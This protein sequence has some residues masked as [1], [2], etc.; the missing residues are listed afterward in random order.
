MRILLV[1][2]NYLPEVTGIGPFN[3]GLAEY[4]AAEGHDVTVLTAFPWYPQW[5]IDPAYRR[6]R[7]FMVERIGGVRIIRSPI[8]LPAARQTTFRRVVF[9]SSFALTALPASAGIGGLDAVICVSPPLQL[10]ITA[11]MI[12]RTRRAKLILHV[13][14]IVPDAALSS[15]MMHAGRAVAMS[16]GLEGWVYRR[17]DRITVISEGFRENLLAKRVPVDKL[18]VLPNWVETGLFKSKADPGVRSALG[19]PN[20]ET[21]VLHTGN[22]GAKQGLETVVDA[23]AQLKSEDIAITLIGDGQARA[24]LESR[25]AELGV[26]KLRFLP[27][28]SDLPATLAAANILVLSQRAQVTDSAAP[29]K[30][31]TYMAAGKPIVATVNSSSEAGQ[32]IERAKCGLVVQPENP[33]DLAAALLRLH[34]HPEMHHA[35]GVA[36]RR[37][38]AR[39]YDRKLIL[40]SWKELVETSAAKRS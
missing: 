18:E 23:A 16:R 13:Q 32:L 14:D 27:L 19:A 38:V 17:A 30:L 31:L 6:K 4:L 28:Q 1:G 12:A 9:D 37:H 36:G 39:H 25:A 7:P 3:V 10:G 22:M 8:L 21:L 40:K 33:A 11:W 20:G 26:H 5:R 35:M 29:S 24:A 15:G 34:R 2:I